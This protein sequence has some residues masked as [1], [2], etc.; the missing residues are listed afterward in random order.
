MIGAAPR[1]PLTRPTRLAVTAAV[2]LIAPEA[3]AV[4]RW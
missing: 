1:S 4:I 2:I 3:R